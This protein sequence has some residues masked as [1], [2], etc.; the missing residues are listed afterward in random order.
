M[1]YFITNEEENIF[2]Y[3]NK[4]EIRRCGKEVGKIFIEA[5]S[6]DVEQQQKPYFLILKDGKGH[7]ASLSKGFIAVLNIK[8]N[9]YRKKN[10]KISL[11]FESIKFDELR[12]TFILNNNYYF[13]INESK[14]ENNMAIIEIDTMESRQIIMIYA[15][16]DVFDNYLLRFSKYVTFQSIDYTP[17][18]SKSYYLLTEHLL[19]SV[20]MIT[21]SQQYNEFYNLLKNKI[22]GMIKKKDGTYDLCRLKGS[23]D[24]TDKLLILPYILTIGGEEVAKDILL[25]YK[26]L[27]TYIYLY[28]LK[29][30]IAHTRDIKFYENK[31]KLKVKRP[32]NIIEKVAR[33]VYL[34]KMNSHKDV[35]N[36]LKELLLEEDKN[37]LDKL[38]LL[39]PFT[40]RYLYNMITSYLRK[41][42]E[43][44]QFFSLLETNEYSFLKLKKEEHIFFTYLY[45][46][47]N[48]ANIEVNNLSHEL[49]IYLPEKT[50]ISKAK[51][52]CDEIK[53]VSLNLS[54]DMIRKKLW[55]DYEAPQYH[56]TLKLHLPWKFD[57][58]IN[59]KYLGKFKELVYEVE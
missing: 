46:T 13:Y 54:Y 24:E 47:R 50:T 44:K 12:D 59:G 5:M 17:F 40:S 45:L 53:S 22:I 35:D 57:V 11:S 25:K 15:H 26:H 19:E 48:I 21:D 27:N 16:K 4:L 36:L 58:A 56:Y 7:I 33:I 29:H 39:L 43:Y 34:N 49:S 6:L 2:V 28:A 14:I 37:D 42:E 8:N 20:N 52:R 3:P 51:I 23:F 18:L 55:L 10:I 32:S 38:L 1:E 30:Y 41:Y 31:N 9:D